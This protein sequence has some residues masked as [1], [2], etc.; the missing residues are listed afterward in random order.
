MDAARGWTV[1]GSA[2]DT[3]AR[4]RSRGRKG[5][6][7]VFHAREEMQG[8]EA[9]VGQSRSAYGRGQRSQGSDGQRHAGC[10]RN[11][12]CEEAVDHGR[13][14]QGRGQQSS[15]GVNNVGRRAGHR[16]KAHRGDGRA[17]AARAAADPGDEQ[18]HLHRR[19][20]HVQADHPTGVGRGGL[21]APQAVRDAAAQ[22]GDAEHRHRAQHQLL[23][24]GDSRG[25]G[26]GR[27]LGAEAGGERALRPL[28][29][30]LLGGE[31]AHHR[32]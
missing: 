18:V 11:R 24:W 19:R 23:L 26:Q 2:G 16:G 6:R 10:F 9:A 27:V 5:P 3:E 7:L 15:L 31:R 25:P 20:A 17:A 1:G 32:L 30:H 29:R 12:C 4:R 8:C 13:S 28:H 14:A 22:R 21:A